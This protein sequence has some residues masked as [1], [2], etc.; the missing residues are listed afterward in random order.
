MKLNLDEWDTP[1]RMSRL[2][3]SIQECGKM[4]KGI[5]RYE[6]KDKRRQRMK[7]HIAKDLRTGAK[8]SPRVILDRK[9]K[10][11]LEESEGYY[12]DEDE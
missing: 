6:G 4:T 12:F 7:N 11:I 5:N 2:L 9:K 8:Y 3:C 1:T 10:Y